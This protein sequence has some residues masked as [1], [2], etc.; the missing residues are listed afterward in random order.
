MSTDLNL[1]THYALWVARMR[2]LQREYQENNCKGNADELHAAQREVDTLT[3]LHLLP[4]QADPYVTVS[5]G[6]M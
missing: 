1:L 4:G 3:S 5:P 6:E 2:Q